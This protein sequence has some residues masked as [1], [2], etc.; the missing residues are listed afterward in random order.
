M[1]RPGPALESLTRR[2]LDTPAD[3]LAEPRVGGAGTVSLPALV[4]DVMRLH[5]YHVPAHWLDGLGGM[6][7]H[8]R[9]NWLAVAMLA[10]WLM[11]DEWFL[12]QSLP[13]HKLCSLFDGTAG[14]LAETAPAHTFVSNAGYGEELVRVV[15][16]HFDYFPAG[17]SP[18]QASDRLAAVSG[19]ARRRLL[20]ASRAAEKRAREVRAALARKAAEEAA[21]KWTRE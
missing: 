9:R 15:L 3:F 13:R 6:Q 12:A 7:P 1:N 20:E 11:A 5:G 2:L 19:A 4:N 10:C 17:E 21:D 18:E 14:Q 8:A 16:A